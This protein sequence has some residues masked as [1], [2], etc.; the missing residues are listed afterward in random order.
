MEWLADPVMLARLQFAFTTMFH[1][2]WPVFTIG[3]SLFLVVVEALW[4]KTGEVDY[5]RHARFWSKLFL[6]NF[7]LGIVT[8]LPLEFQFGTNWAPF[9]NMAGGFFGN[10]LG[11]EGAAAFMLEAGFV[12]IMIFGWERVAPAMHLFATSMV[13][14]GASASAFWIMAASAWMQSPAGGYFE[15]GVFQVQSYL[16]AIFNPNTPWAVSHMW[17][18]CLETSCFVVGGISAWYILKGQSVSFYARSFRLAAAGAVVVAPLQVWLGDGSGLF[19]VHHQPAKAAAIEGH[20]QTNAPGEGAAWAIL[21]WPDAAAQANRW[22]VQVPNLLSL[23]ATRT[24]HGQVPGLREFAPE[25]RPPALP[26]LFYSFRLMVLIGLYLL[27][28]AL[29]TA[30]AWGRRRLTAE[31]IA[32]QR[33]LLRAWVFAIPLGYVAVEAGWIVREVGRQPWVI[34]GVMR[35]SDGASPLPAG[36][37]GASLGGFLLIYTALAIAFAV[38]ARRLLRHG[39]D[40]TL[41]PS[42]PQGEPFRTGATPPEEE[43]R[44]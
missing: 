20:W 42:P 24:P 33:W 27:T 39:P 34:Y 14:L 38:F 10:V 18:A 43:E 26:L 28:L 36:A 25:D 37:V 9:S 8:G 41:R 22:S 11:F 17:V 35:T 40:L 12:G 2:I 7:G 3:L 23:L 44:P 16:E 19:I 1:I 4:L 13:A 31:A 32:A 6:L 30:W 29:W 15:N 5:Y 21:A